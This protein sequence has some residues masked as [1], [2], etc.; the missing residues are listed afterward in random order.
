[1]RR[2]LG[3]F[4]EWLLAYRHVVVVETK[5]TYSS[6]PSFHY[7]D[8]AGFDLFV[9]RSMTIPPGDVMDVPSGLMLDPKDRLWFEI[10]ARSST[11]RKRGLEVQ[12]AV[13]DRGYRG[14]MFAIVHNPTTH[15][16]IIK[17]GERICQ[18]VPHRVI[19][20]KFRYGAVS[21]SARGRRG[22]CSTGEQNDL[23]AYTYRIFTFGFH[24]KSPCVGGAGKA[25]WYESCWNCGPWN[26]W[27]VGGFVC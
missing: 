27:G 4:I 5:S 12:D 10:K 16:V 9:S 21:I 7:D 13:I 26:S 1:M 2:L 19:P 20:C 11:F 8:D 24:N 25:S 23:V 15:N 14:E 18:I 3:R 17:V 6:L 22:F